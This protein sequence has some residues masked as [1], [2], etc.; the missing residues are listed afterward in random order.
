MPRINYKVCRTC[1]FRCPH[2]VF[3]ESDSIGEYYECKHPEMDPGKDKMIR[4]GG[5]DGYGDYLHF[6]P[7]FGCILWEKRDL[8]G[9]KS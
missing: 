1:K 9:D 3:E 2:T 8:V 5:E 6:R 7:N 4:A